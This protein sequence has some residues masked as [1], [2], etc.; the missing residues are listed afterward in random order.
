[1]ENFA[2]KFVSKL[3]GKLCATS[4]TNMFHEKEFIIWK[5]KELTYRLIRISRTGRR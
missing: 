2:N 1:M 4:T 3:D 5:S